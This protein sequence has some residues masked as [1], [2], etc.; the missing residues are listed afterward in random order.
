M[1][2]AREIVFGT[3]VIPLS[4]V[5]FLKKNSYA[6]VNHKP[7]VAGHVLVCSKRKVN[8]IQELT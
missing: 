3:H 8:K 7:F 4:Q 6:M 1:T 5:F 2:L